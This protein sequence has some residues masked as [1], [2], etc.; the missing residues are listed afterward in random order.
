MNCE[1]EILDRTFSKIPG[2]L[3]YGGRACV[4][5]YHS[6]EDRIIKDKIRELSKTG[7]LKTLTKK[8]V[9]P[10]EKEVSLN[11]R[12]RSARLRAAERTEKDVA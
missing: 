10:Q 3:S 6:L 11:P 12:A 8:P 5:S 4:I 1:L 2:L 9:R 7:I